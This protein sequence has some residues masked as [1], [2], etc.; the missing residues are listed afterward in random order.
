[1]IATLWASRL[2]FR[3]QRFEIVAIGVFVAF[4]AA[5]AAIIAFRLDS[6]GYSRECAVLDMRGIGA[7]RCDP[8]A[9]LFWTLDG[10]EASP[11]LVLLS[12]L[13]FV[14][15]L[16]V[17]APV[18][19]R[20]IERG[21]ARL[22][23]SLAPSRLGWYLRRT[24]PVVVSVTILAYLAGV[25]ADHL[26]AARS[27]AIDPTRSFEHYGQ[28]GVLLAAQAL[29][30][31]AGSIALGSVIGRQLPT[32]IVALVLGVGGVLGV[33]R[34]HADLTAREA[35]VRDGDFQP[36][37]RWVDQGFRIP[38]GSIGDWSDAEAF[39]PVG[40][41]N[42]TFDLPPVA[43]VIPGERYRE[44]E[45]REALILTA[46][47]GVMLVGAAAVVQRRRPD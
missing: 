37:D 39:D 21:T 32:A 13:P 18:I 28:R 33:A 15:G 10:N 42:G 3:L 8:V 45:A 12:I 41:A 35:I 9:Q 25:A 44:I 11:V 31:T 14:A 43:I 29:V 34:I 16:F 4:L 46:I 47:A 1:M 5:L 36:G 22:A 40:F 23:W 20:E 26:W 2:T 17:G 7:R 27:L 38:D 19:S 24:I 30:L 6:V